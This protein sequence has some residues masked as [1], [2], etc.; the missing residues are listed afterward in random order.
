M[1]LYR[2]E[3][4]AI[5]HRADIGRQCGR[6]AGRQFP[7]RAPDHLD[8]CVGD[9]LVTAEQ[10]QRRAALAGRAERALHHRIDDLLGQ[11]RAV[12]QHGVDAASL[13]NQG[14]DGAVLGSQRTVDDSCHLRRAG[15][16]DARH[17]GAATQ[18][19]DAH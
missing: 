5:D 14:N 17:A 12:N 13:G 15:E 9:A 11:C 7:C 4:L 18:Q 1:P 10:A 2:V 6:V 8:H 16:H 19:L 3:G